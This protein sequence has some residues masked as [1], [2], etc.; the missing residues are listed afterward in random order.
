[1]K[2][3]YNAYF[4]SQTQWES[5]EALLNDMGFKDPDLGARL[6][7]DADL[8][9]EVEKAFAK[10][11]MDERGWVYLA[12]HLKFD[13]V[14]KEAFNTYTEQFVRGLPEKEIEKQKVLHNLRQKVAA[15]QRDT[16]EFSFG[17]KAPEKSVAK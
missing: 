7:Y 14:F 3:P 8:L 1:M 12:Q 17:E 6:E 11:R 13:P 4:D 2:T 9:R 10:A 5:F 16:F 15:A